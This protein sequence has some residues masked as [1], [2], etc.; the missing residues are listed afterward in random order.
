MASV[1]AKQGEANSVHTIKSDRSR[2]VP[3]N[4]CPLETCEG[5]RPHD[6]DRVAIL[7]E[8]KEGELQL[9]RNAALLNQGAPSPHIY[10]VLDGVLLRQVKLEDGSRQIVNFM[11][12]GDLVGLQAAID[13]NMEHSVEALTDATLCVFQRDKFSDLIARQPHFAYDVIWLAAKEESALESHLV[14]L[15]K[16][17]AHERVAYLAVYLVQ[18]GIQTGLAQDN[19]EAR[20]SIPI[21]QRQIADMLGLSLVHTNRTMQALRQS[22]LLHWDSDTIIIEDMD[23]ACD[24]A[25]FDGLNGAPRPYL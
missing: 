14:A 13:Q 17:N 7:Q 10:T 6:P 23:A 21:T 1:V 22:N 18:R 19:G 16:R 24:Y 9:S 25:K 20:L 2:W 3:C 15:G 8:F 5:L 11:F 4:A 12:P